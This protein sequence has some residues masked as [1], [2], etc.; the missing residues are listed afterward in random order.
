MRGQ[1]VVTAGLFDIEKIIFGGDLTQRQDLNPVRLSVGRI[2]KQVA[3]VADA[4]CVAHCLSH[5]L[6]I[7]A[8]L[9]GI[10]HIQYVTRVRA[11]LVVLTLVEGCR[12]IQPG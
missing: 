5:L 3:E 12:L 9:R 8:A 10:R 11:V 1:Q 7:A 6:N 4:F 2:H